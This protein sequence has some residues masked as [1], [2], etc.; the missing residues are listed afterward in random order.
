MLSPAHSFVETE[1][2]VGGRRLMRLHEAVANLMQPR[3]CADVQPCRSACLER[4]IGDR[5]SDTCELVDA[6]MVRALK[7]RDGFLKLSQRRRT[8]KT[9][10]SEVDAAGQTRRRVR[11]REERGAVDEQCWR[12]SEV[13]RFCV[14]LRFNALL[15]HG[16]VIPICLNDGQ[17]LG[18]GF[19]VRAPVEVLQGDL[20][21]STL[22]A[23]EGRWPISD[24]L[25]VFVTGWA[26]VV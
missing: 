23:G 5:L 4:P 24:Y 26:F 20:H 18:C 21:L 8:C 14:G 22:N 17:T 9:I 3:A 13:Q 10:G 1:K 19:P 2:G 15:D 12:A 6:L 11:G 7:R 16:E 25:P